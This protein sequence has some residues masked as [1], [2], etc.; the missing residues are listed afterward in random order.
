[1]QS[2]NS[3]PS[4][5]QYVSDVQQQMTDSQTASSVELS[6]AAETEISSMQLQVIQALKLEVAL[7]RQFRRV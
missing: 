5:Q 7:S 2:L 1:M 4:I 6:N 3:T